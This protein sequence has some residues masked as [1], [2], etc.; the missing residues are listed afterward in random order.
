MGHSVD[1]HADRL[2]TERLGY[3]NS[4]PQERI[5]ANLKSTIANRRE[6]AGAL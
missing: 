5:L 2:M 3:A 1:A 4:L 6:D